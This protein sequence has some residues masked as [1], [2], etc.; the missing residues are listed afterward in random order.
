MLEGQFYT[1]LILNIIIGIMFAY[2]MIKM[3]QYNNRESETQKH[4]LMKVFGWIFIGL[5]G[6]TLISSIVSLVNVDFP[7]S[8]I[9]PVISPNTIVRSPSATLYWGY[10]TMIQSSVLSSISGVFAFLGIGGY[11]LFFKSS[12]SNWWNKILKFFTVLLLYAFMASATNLHFFDFWE[13]NAPI[14]FL[15]LFFIILNRKPKN[16]TNQISLETVNNEIITIEENNDISEDSKTIEVLNET[17][18]PFI[19]SNSEP[20]DLIIQGQVNKS[21]PIETPLQKQNVYNINDETESLDENISIKFCRHCGKEID[22]DSLFCKHCGKS[23]RTSKQKKNYTE[24]IKNALPL[25]LDNFK[26]VFKYRI[27]ISSTH[28][29]KIKTFLKWV[30]PTVLILAL[31]YII[32]MGI[33]YYFDVIKPEKDGESIYQSEINNINNLQGEELQARCEDIIR[34]HNIPKTGKYYIDNDN[35]TKLTNISWEKIGKLAQSGNRDAQFLLALKY[36]GYDFHNQRWDTRTTE[37]GLYYNSDL[38]YDKAAYWYL[39]AANQGHSTAQSNLGNCYEK[40]NGVQRNMKEAVKWY[41]IS[42]ENGNQWGQLNLGDCYRDGVKVKVGSHKE[43]IKTTSYSYNKGEKIRE[44]Y[45]HNT[46]EFVKIYRIEVDDYEYIIPQDME[47]AL[48]WWK[49][50]AAQ[51]N[52]QAKERLQKIY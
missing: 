23:I 32:G 40:G 4:P 18:P 46:M 28:K 34:N 14:F 33:D 52:D 38:D 26:K 30:G 6:L 47:Q 42:A 17:I 15:I 39:Q 20:N 50:S 51:G 36:N 1:R 41:Q 16:I 37:N 9:G 35:I 48:Y 45:D 2:V 5:S 12:K 10:P 11:L 7:P 27:K 24:F 3:A 44:Y 22:T 8:M 21:Q 29:G 31:L 19:T 25:I 13:L 49:K 43:D